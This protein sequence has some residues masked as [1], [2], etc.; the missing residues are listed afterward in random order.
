MKILAC[1]D[2]ALFREGL[3]HV[4][5]GLA[6]GATWLDASNAEE[7]WSA[8]DQHDDVDLMLLDLTLAETDGISVLKGV[9]KKRP[10]IP[11]AIVSQRERITDLENAFRA[12]AAG[13]IPKSSSGS[14]MRAALQLILSGG[15]YL[16][17]FALDLA[18]PQARRR[19]GD[20]RFGHLTE[21]QKDVARLAARGLTNG[22]IAGQLRIREA[23]VKAHL[24]TI[25][26]CLHVTSRT[27]VGAVL[28]S[29]GLE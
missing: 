7:V 8:L 1:D 18:H 29:L 19:L 20:H 16:P 21:R 13:F 26:Q 6:P 17:P 28:R 9:K 11:V 5:E 22:E 10:E 25:F 27:E 2:H 4:V 24:A 15:I 14:V 3:R 23:T 12:G